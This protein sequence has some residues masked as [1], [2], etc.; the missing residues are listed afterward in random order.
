M[1]LG[2]PICTLPS[3]SSPRSYIRTSIL[4]K[5]TSFSLRLDV[6]TCSKWSQWCSWQSQTVQ[7]TIQDSCCLLIKPLQSLFSTTG[8]VP[9]HHFGLAGPRLSAV[10][11]PPLAAVFQ[12]SL[13]SLGRGVPGPPPAPLHLTFSAQVPLP[14]LVLSTPG[15]LCIL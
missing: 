3:G 13:P 12:I 6:A 15:F 9:P 8:H 7:I 4:F 14:C 1:G 11:L 10:H 5:N 2:E